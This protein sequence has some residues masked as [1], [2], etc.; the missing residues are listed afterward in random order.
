MIL[1]DEN[2]PEDQCDTLRSYRIRFQQVGQDV[3]R[4]GMKDEEHVV[5]LLH[6]LNRP[7]F[8]TRDLGFFDKSRCHANYCLA[9]LAVSQKEAAAFIRR[10]LR[11]PSFKTKSKRLGTVVWI[12]HEGMRVWR[13]HAKT[14]EKVEWGD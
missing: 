3:G 10:F 6:Q 9:C 5:P 8:V 7:T 2:I 14:E 13:L 11:H 12:A 4:Q 1:L